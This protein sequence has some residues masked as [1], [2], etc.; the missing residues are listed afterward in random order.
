MTTYNGEA[1]LREQIDSL[2][3]QTYAPYEI[4]IQ[5]DG[6]TDGTWAILQDYAQRYAIIKPFHNEDCHG[7]NGNLYS[8]MRRATGD[9]FAICDQDDIWE[10]EKIAG[11]VEKIGNNLLIGGQTI[12]FS[13]DGSAVSYDKR[14][15]NHHILRLLF[16]SA[17]PGHSMLLRPEILKTY[18]PNNDSCYDAHL[19]VV[20]AALERFCF[21]GVCP[22]RQRRHASA[23]TYTKPVNNS[24]GMGNIL[25]YLLDCIRIYPK[26]HPVLVRRMKAWQILLDSIDADTESLRQAREMTRLMQGKGIVSK[27]RQALFCHR[28]RRY[29]FHTVEQD[30]LL[31]RIRALLFPLTAV[32][33][34]RTVA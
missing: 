17:I 25:T 31:L 9:L 6:S 5:D 23:L 3:A 18:T 27:L 2:L 12:P 32:Y 20:A 34:F 7:I 11:Q 4:I 28:H 8:A 19:Q 1:H 33:Y 10:P 30:S 22:V 24:H 15:P 29:L 26:A 16:A 13:T 14:T 21:Q